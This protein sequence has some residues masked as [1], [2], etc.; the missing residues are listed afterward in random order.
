MSCQGERA[1]LRKPLVNTERG[2]SVMDLVRVILHGFRSEIEVERD[3]NLLSAVREA[4]LGIDSECGGRGTCGDCR[5]RFLE[6]APPPS[7]EDHLLLGPAAARAGWRLACQASLEQDCRIVIPALAPDAALRILTEAT[8][9]EP[10][11]KGRGRRRLATGHGAAIDIGTTTVVCYLVDLAQARQIGV[12]AFANPQQAFGADVVS[13]I[14]YAHRDSA[15]L[16]ELQSCLV[17]A[18]EE[19]LVEL[20]SQHSV[21]LD[22]VSSLTAVGNLTMMHLFRGV[23]PWPLGVAPYQPVFTESPPLAAGALGFRRLGHAQVA[24]L[25]GVGGQI[26]SDAVAGL[27]ALGVAGWR[28]PTLFI[29]L[30]TN[31]EIVL[32]SGRMAVGC[33]CAAG[34]AF[35]GVHISSGMAAVAGAVE[36]VEEENGHLRLDTIDGSPPLGLCGSGLADALTVLL[37]RG[38]VLPSGRLLGPKQIPADVPADLRARMREDEGQRRFV[39]HEDEL[40]KPILLTQADIRQVQLAKAAVRAGAEAALEAAGLEPDSIERVFVGGAFGSSMRSDSLLALGM[41]PEALRGRIHPVGNVAGM[42]AKLA[43]IFPERLREAGRLAR[44]IRHVSLAEKPDFSS[45]FAAHLSFPGP[46]KDG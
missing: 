9:P 8:L 26:G 37:R 6:G 16:A 24:L 5:V 20:C 39:L 22:T 31:G 10:P 43:L 12:A 40:A 21:S 44:R 28:E 3:S 41:L 34:P 18:I 29:D 46:E 1:L 17:S 19:H 25:P 14:V 7:L 35:E 36:R 4:G 33:S 38:L 13:R 27:L 15:Q 11:R 32:L 42:G 30:G 45:G 2:S 23:D